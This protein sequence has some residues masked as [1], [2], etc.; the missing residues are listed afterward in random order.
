M[1]QAKTTIASGGRIVIPSEIR[2]ELNLKVGE[3]V[4]LKVESGQI[5]IISYKQ[6]VKKAQDTVRKYNK[7][8]LSL[9]DL[10]FKQ[11]KEESDSEE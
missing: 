6:A 3:E 1:L 10:L 7:K 8:K 4:L 5:H 2:N 9:K 11:R